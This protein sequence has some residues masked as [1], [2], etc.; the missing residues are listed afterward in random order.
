MSETSFT[1]SF[2]GIALTLVY[3]TICR[4]CQKIEDWFSQGQTFRKVGCPHK[5]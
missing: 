1:P 2:N 4:V 5:K 3:T